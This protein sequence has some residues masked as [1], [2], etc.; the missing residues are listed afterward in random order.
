MLQKLSLQTPDLDIFTSAQA[1]RYPALPMLHCDAEIRQS[2]QGRLPKSLE[3]P[4]S[5]NKTASL[6][7]PSKVTCQTAGWG[8]LTL[9]SWPL[10]PSL[11]APSK[12]FSAGS[13]PSSTPSP[14]FNTQTAELPATLGL[15]SLVLSCSWCQTP[16]CG[17]ASHQFSLPCLFMRLIPALIRREVPTYEPRWQLSSGEKNLCSVPIFS[18]LILGIFP[19]QGVSLWLPFHSHPALPGHCSRSPASHSIL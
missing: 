2:E 14:A 4:S 16:A 6:L 15:R 18:Q 13:S 17:D 7:P 5:K 19:A 9:S 10:R 8:S 12:V 3:Q 1:V 11:Q